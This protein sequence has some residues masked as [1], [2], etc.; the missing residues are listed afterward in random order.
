[1]RTGIAEAW[2][3]IR[4]IKQI[5]HRL[6][7]LVKEATGKPGSATRGNR[8]ADESLGRV[9]D[10]LISNGLQALFIA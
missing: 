1:M 3:A 4:A 9:L 6:Q 8:H 2:Q 7:V 5:G 10:I